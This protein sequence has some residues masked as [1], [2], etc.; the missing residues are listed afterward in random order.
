MNRTLRIDP[1]QVLQKL[2]SQRLDHEDSTTKAEAEKQLRNLASMSKKERRERT[3]AFRFDGSPEH[4]H[5]RA[6]PSVSN[7]AGTVSETAQVFH[8]TSSEGR[9]E[10]Q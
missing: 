1:K 5:G 10:W 3:E 7:K 6:N 4:V 8:L 2:H 9:D